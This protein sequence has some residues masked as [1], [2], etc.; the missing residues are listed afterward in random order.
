MAPA[1]I[2]EVLVVDVSALKL[3][4]TLTIAEIAL[5]AFAKALHDQTQIV[6]QVRLPHVVEEPAETEPAPAEGDAAAA[7]AA[8]AADAK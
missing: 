5:P 4:D 1:D 3:D 7:A 6:F 2:P 8:P